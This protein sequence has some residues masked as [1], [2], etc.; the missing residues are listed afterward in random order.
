MGSLASS[1]WA[2]R[3]TNGRNFEADLRGRSPGNRR[4]LAR[5]TP[6]SGLRAA[7]IRARAN[8]L[9]PNYRPVDRSL[10]KFIRLSVARSLIARLLP[11]GI[12]RELVARIRPISRRRREICSF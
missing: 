10:R 12:S 3:K 4:A 2:V 7:E 5:G 8:D 11:S 9:A 6:P 1:D